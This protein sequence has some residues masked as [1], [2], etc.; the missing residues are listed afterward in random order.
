M[1]YGSNDRKV[2]IK[3][4]QLGRPTIEAQNFAGV[5]C[6]AATAPIEK[7]LAGGSGVTRVLKPEWHN[8][9]TAA[10]QVRESW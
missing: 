5:G 4:D 8:E 3:I 10:E 6:E 9:E 2:I 7:A 1:N